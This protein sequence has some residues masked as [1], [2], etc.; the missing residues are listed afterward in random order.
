M[1]NDNSKLPEINCDAEP[2]SDLSVWNDEASRFA[3]SLLLRCNFPQEGTSYKCAVS[4]GPD[5][6]ALL[7]LAVR[8]GLR[9][10]CYH[11]DHQIREGSHLEATKV[12]SAAKLLGAEFVA[13][14]V[15]VEEG[16]NLEA[17]ARALR[18]AALPPDAATGHTLDDQAETV[19]INLLRGAGLDGLSGMEINFSHPILRIRRWE[20][21]KLTELLG[22]DPVMDPSNDD[23]RF[24]RNRVRHELLPLCNEIARRDVAVLLARTA[25]VVS[26]E[27]ELLEDLAA[28]IKAD[29]VAEIL[30]V[31]EVLAKRALRGWLRGLNAEKHPPSYE[32][33][34]R[35]MEVAKKKRLACQL[36]GGIDVHRSKGSLVV[37]A[38]KT[39]T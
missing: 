11:V 36:P 38:S 16:P 35:V 37:R 25:E 13:L 21:R 4:G 9:V 32:S 14:S 3:D 23:P 34:E 33:L 15:A 2:K 18:K 8:A 17:R 6:L 20:T 27:N 31:Q 22:L 30:Q 19:L 24:L 5:S 29:S 1:G 7:A 12:R 28:G 10:T 39:I 26:A